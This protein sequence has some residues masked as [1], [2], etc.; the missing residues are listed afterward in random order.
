M[1]RR[2]VALVASPA[3]PRAKGEI[4]LE[5]A[6]HFLDVLLEKLDLGVVHQRERQFEARQDRAEIMADAVEHGRALLERA[7]DAP[8][9]FDEGVAG[10]PDFPRAMRTE[11]EIAALAEIL[12]RAGEP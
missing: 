7:L 11:I 10:L 12:R 9:H 8:L 2:S 5:H 4:A 1:V 3:S 6:L